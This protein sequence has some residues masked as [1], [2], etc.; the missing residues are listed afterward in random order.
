MAEL[1]MAAGQRPLARR[2]KRMLQSHYDP[3]SKV[4]VLPLSGLVLGVALG[5]ALSTE[6]RPRTIIQPE[7]SPQISARIL[8]R[9]AFFVDS[10]DQL[11]DAERM[12]VSGDFIVGQPT[13]AVKP[14]AEALASKD[15]A[16]FNRLKELGR[17][18]VTIVIDQKGEI[19]FVH[20]EDPVSEDLQKP[21]VDVLNAAR[22]E[23][24]THYSQGPAMVEVQI[25]YFINPEPLRK[26]FYEVGQ[27]LV[28][29]EVGE[30][31][32]VAPASPDRKALP[33]REGV[34]RYIAILGKGEPP[35]LTITDGEFVMSFVL[36]IDGHGNVESAT[37]L[38]DS[39]T[40]PIEDSTAAPEADVL[41][42]YLKTFRFE[43]LVLPDGTPAQVSAIVDI[44]ASGRGVE[45]ATRAAGDEEDLDRR[46]SEVYRLEDG[47]NL[48]LLPPPHRP[49]RMLFYRTGSPSQ[50]RAIPSGPDQM[51]IL[52]KG[53]RATY[54]GSCFGCG[55]LRSVLRSL[56]FRGDGIRFEGEAENIAI[57][58]DIVIRESAAKEELLVELG[59][60]LKEKF[61]LNL[62]FEMTAE[63]TKTLVLRGTIG[64]VP[65][66]DVREGQRVLNVYTDRKNEDSRIGAGGGPF[67][68]AENLVRLLSSQ[69]AMPVV[70][71]TTGA[72]SYPYHVRIHDSA[73][74]TRRF[75]LLI[76]NLEAQTNLDVALEDRLQEMVAVVRS[77]S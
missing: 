6:A 4:G 3:N 70:D 63:M 75:D 13:T 19:V 45:I 44:R 27:I 29:D 17:I 20:F 71:E 52:W 16:L 54:G 73:H 47:R 76:Q 35:H 64:A 69:L 33:L 12:Q 36:S 61:D 66:D 28:G 41:A 30:I 25:E 11:E 23:P 5:V 72:A 38:G 9:G 22:F 46:F 55:D 34:P 59:Q 2:L 65:E 14:D 18:A 50:A 1:G 8:W 74:A 26:S 7:S 42:H 58:A 68:D 15:P 57:E 62:R 40:D 48:D 43:P 67:L 10:L 37:L 31:S 51:T 60:I 32:R 53:E 56:G 24:T 21:F 49:E 77:E 39:R